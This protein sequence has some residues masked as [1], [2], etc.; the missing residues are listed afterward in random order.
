[1]SARRATVEYGA[2]LVVLVTGGVLCLVAASRPWGEATVHDGLAATTTAVTGRDLFPLAP[3]VGLLAVAAV[4]AVPA[5]RRVGRR[6]VGTVLVAAGL[7]TALGSYGLALELPARV[8][9]WAERSG[10]T[11]GPVE[12]AIAEPNWARLTVLGGVLIAGAG[13]AVAVRG[14]RWPGMGTR[15]ER[16][17]RA[18]EPRTDPP[19]TVTGRETWDAL[20]R[21]DD[22]TA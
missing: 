4:V 19:P 16:D 5:A 18:G 13:L 11:T 17:A 9:T 7:A 3:A 21:G 20:D 2:A 6:V 15:Y 10:S 22:P 14:P 12:E 8:M 1:V